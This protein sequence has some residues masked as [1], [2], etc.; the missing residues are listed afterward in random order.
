MRLCAKD[1][2]MDAMSGALYGQNL[3]CFQPIGSDQFIYI[4]KSLKNYNW[5]EELSNRSK[6]KVLQQDRAETD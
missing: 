2:K 6:W 5:T 1:V 4:Q 3:L